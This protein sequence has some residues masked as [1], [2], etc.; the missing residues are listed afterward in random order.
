VPSAVPPILALA[1]SMALLAP[2][3]ALASLDPPDVPAGLSDSR[4]ADSLRPAP[5]Q[6][7]PLNPAPPSWQSVS[8][9]AVLGPNYL[10]PPDPRPQAELYGTPRTDWKRSMPTVGLGVGYRIMA[11]DDSLPAV[12]GSLRLLN[13]GNPVVSSISA[14]STVTLPT[15][16]NC[17]FGPGCQSEYRVA[18]TIDF[19]QQG[20]LGLYLGGGAALNKDSLHKNYGMMVFG[21][22]LSMS[23][24]LTL[25]TNLNWIFNDQPDD[26]DQF[27]GLRWAD[28]E[29][30]FSVNLRL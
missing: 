22:E 20:A 12:Q 30:I 26:T 18:G 3:A 25:T 1:A 6:P 7:A 27:G 29:T 10:L 16:S 19:F 5:W 28:V 23:R 17:D 15:R 2:P 8:N 4:P 11:Q 13:T 14:R 24:N 21:A 9:E